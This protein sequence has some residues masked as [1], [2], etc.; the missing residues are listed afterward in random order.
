MASPDGSAKTV[1]GRCSITQKSLLV[2]LPSTWW[3]A[4]AV[5][6]KKPAGNSLLIKLPFSVCG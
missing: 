6:H 3:A 4:V 2:L 1:P 5:P